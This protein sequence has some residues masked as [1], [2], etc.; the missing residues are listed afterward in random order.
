MIGPGQRGADCRLWREAD[1]RDARY[2]VGFVP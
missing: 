2:D 1:I